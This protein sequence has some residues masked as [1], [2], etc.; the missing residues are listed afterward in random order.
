MVGVEGGCH[1]EFIK[2]ILIW[3]EVG[4]SKLV[5]S[6]DLVHAEDGHV[7]QDYVLQLHAL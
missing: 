1:P 3:G 7:S 6:H 4:I 5:D 2:E